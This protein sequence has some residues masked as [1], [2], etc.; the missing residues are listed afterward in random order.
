MCRIGLTVAVATLLVASTAN[1][2]EKKPIQ[3][4]LV[5]PIQIFP[6]TYE[7]SGF[8]FNLLYGRNA[9]M[10]GFDLGL[11][12]HVTGPVT[13]VQWGAVNVS[14]AFVGWQSALV[15][16]NKT[17]FEGFQHGAVNVTGG[18]NGLQL[19]VVNYAERADGCIQIGLVNIIKEG[20]MFP[21]M[22]LVNWGGL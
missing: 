15:N 2:Q 8:R 7:I 21:V 9:S 12:N 19:A 18:M 17:G 22:I 6:D 1:T 5:T 13:G 14:N 20:G 4:S 10:S 11:V 16:M 3:L